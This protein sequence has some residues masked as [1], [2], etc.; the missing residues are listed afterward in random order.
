MANSAQSFKA[1]QCKKRPQQTGC[2]CSKSELLVIPTNPVGPCRHLIRV[3][4]TVSMHSS[5][6]A[7]GLVEPRRHELDKFRERVARV[8]AEFWPAMACANEAF[9]HRRLRAWAFGGVTQDLLARSERC[10]LV[11]HCSDQVRRGAN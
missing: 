3:R 9:G 1:P 4:K 8:E 5:V 11:S 6:V 7:I 2:S 10:T